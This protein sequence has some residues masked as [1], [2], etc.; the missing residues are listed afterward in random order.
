MLG[1]ILGGLVFLISTLGLFGVCC[2][3]IMATTLFFYLDF[4]LSLILL[5]SMTII[6]LSANNIST[7][8]E[9]DGP[10][11]LIQQDLQSALLTQAVDSPSAWNMT[12]QTFSCCGVDLNSTYLYDQY[13]MT[14]AEFVLALQPGDNCSDVRTAILAL[15]AKYSTY[16]NETE[17]TVSAIPFCKKIVTVFVHDH[18]LAI[19]IV[20]GVLVWTG[21]V[22]AYASFLLLCRVSTEKGGFVIPKD[23]NGNGGQLGYEGGGKPKMSQVSNGNQLV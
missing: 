13:N 7:T 19:G 1:F 2:K 17:S 16:N 20:A 5:V 6:I 18:T 12:E 23:Q 14:D 10:I 4:L 3:S 15:H 9:I 21:L 11:A 8:P 22:S